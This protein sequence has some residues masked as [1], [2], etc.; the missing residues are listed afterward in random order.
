QADTVD[1][2]LRLDRHPEI[3]QAIDAY[4]AGPWRRWA[5]SEKP[6]RETIAIY[7]RFFRVLQTIEAE[8]VENPTEVVFG[9]GMALW[10]TEGQ[11]IEHPLI[12]ALME[13]DIDP[14]THAIRVSPR[15]TEPQVY[16]KPYYRD[17]QPRC[18][19]ATQSC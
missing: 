18:G 3:Q 15:E 19:W 7:D 10:K 1:V 2:R 17:R 8:G 4:S 11:T 12:E 9:A 6:R 16:L 13:I 14:K 5:E